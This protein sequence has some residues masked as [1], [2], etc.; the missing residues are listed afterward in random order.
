ME[1]MA[2]KVRNALKKLG[3]SGEEISASALAEHM[4]LRTHKK[5]IPLYATLTDMRK[6]GEVISIKKGVYQFKPIK[7]TLLRTI[8]WRILRAGKKASVEDLM[9]LAGASEAYAQEWL[10]MLEKREIVKKMKG[11]IYRLVDDVVIEPENTERVERM[12]NWRKKKKLAMAAL[13]K[14][15]K[16]IDTAKKALKED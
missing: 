9:E 1:S 15:S 12:R 5:K 2:G 16:A 4:G 11:G 7:K 6:R 10:R 13:D 8:M 3:R 14:A